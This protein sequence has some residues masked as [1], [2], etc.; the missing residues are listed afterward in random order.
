MLV[1]ANLVA[2]GHASLENELSVRSIGICSWAIALLGCVRRF[3]CQ[4]EGLNN[5]V[6]IRV[7]RQVKD[8]LRH[9][10]ADGKDFLVQ[11][12]RFIA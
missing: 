7:G 10:C 8:I 2:V 4:Q 9:F 3:E 12:L 5:V 6:T 11:S 1:R